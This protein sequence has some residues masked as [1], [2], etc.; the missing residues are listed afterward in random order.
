[1]VAVVSVAYREIDW[2][3]PAA[4]PVSIGVL[5]EVSLAVLAKVAMKRVPK[6]AD[7]LPPSV[8]QAFYGAMSN[9]P[10]RAARAAYAL[11]PEN[12][13]I[14][15]AEKL[16]AWLKTS[17]AKPLRLCTV[18][19]RPCA[20]LARPRHRPE[21]PPPD[22][23]DDLCEH[24]FQMIEVDKEDKCLPLLIRYQTIERRLV[25]LYRLKFPNGIG[26]ISCHYAR[27]KIWTLAER[28]H[29]FRHSGGIGGDENDVEE[30]GDD[31]ENDDDGN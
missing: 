3:G 6:V 9:G 21:T 24:D 13:R 7:D 2:Y 19:H 22:G 1:M 14:G 18:P 29:L 5:E 15:D 16:E 26:F 20:L 28:N 8:I 27:L 30:E 4:L 23:W 25:R 11:N 12:I 31:D 17:E 10:P